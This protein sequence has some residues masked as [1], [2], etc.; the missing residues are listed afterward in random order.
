MKINIYPRHECSKAEGLCVVIDVLRA[1]TTA[2]FAFGSGA[3]EIFLV[4]SPEDA[5]HKYSQ[6]PSLVLMGEKG[7]RRIEGFHYGN[8]PVDI[9]RASL[10]G[11]SIVQR[12]SSGTQGVVGCRH[13][14]HLMIASF[15]VAK[16]TLKHILALQPS[17]ASF[18]VTGT[19]NGDEDLS[20]A[21]Y[22]QAQILG[23]KVSLHSFLDR[24]RT[25]PLGKTF[26]D[27]AIPEFSQEDLQYALQADR[28]SFA[29]EVFKEGEDLIARQVAT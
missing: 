13:A 11:R 20:L 27:P 12:T 10:T 14:S 16:A 3:K 18:I 7:G 6:D 17:I 26:A 8:S 24:V 22:L 15:V 19:R 21:E 29:M 1:F 9:A 28:F 5:F 25:S 2:A 4:S 23:Q